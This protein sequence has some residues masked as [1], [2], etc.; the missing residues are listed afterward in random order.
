M[1]WSCA[2]IALFTLIACTKL[3]AGGKKT[4]SWIDEARGAKYVSD[5]DVAR[6]AEELK[7]LPGDGHA[8]ATKLLDDMAATEASVAGIHADA[9]LLVAA[10]PSFKSAGPV[11]PGSDPNQVRVLRAAMDLMH[12]RVYK[13]GEAT[14]ARPVDVLTELMTAA[15]ELDKLFERINRTS[16]LV[17]ELRL[18]AD[19]DKFFEA[20]DRAEK[21]LSA[22][23]PAQTASAPPATPST[24]PSPPSTPSTPATPSDRRPA[25]NLDA[26]W[27]MLD[28]LTGKLP[29]HHADVAKTTGL[30][31]AK[32]A[33]QP[34]RYYTIY[35]SS[36]PSGHV[37]A[38]ELRER[39]DP[40]AGKNGLVIIDLAK[41]TPCFTQRDAIAKLG[42]PKNLL[43]PRPNEPRDAPVLLVY[44]R[45][46]GELTLAFERSGNECMKGITLDAT[47]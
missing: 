38:I 39:I 46:W 10:L 17:E 7:K 36:K 6:E 21:K 28:R 35:K 15:M 22:G 30:A 4:V 16:P 18:A 40:E 13:V 2:A 3:D 31:L 47:Q 25:P 29:F 1:R 32:A 19:K 37:E 11:P 45:P 42:N 44:K 8:R 34:N 5:K 27:G 14:K 23:T 43:F 33:D 9:K 41:T 12:A 26:L 20:Y 24:Q